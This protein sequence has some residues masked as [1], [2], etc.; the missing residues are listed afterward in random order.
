[1]YDSLSD[2]IMSDLPFKLEYL[3]GKNMFADVLSPPL[4]FSAIVEP[5]AKSIPEILKTAHDE[6]GHMSTKYALQD[7]ENLFYLAYHAG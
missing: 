4:G 7:I 5:S 6:A 1:M 2:E 3:N